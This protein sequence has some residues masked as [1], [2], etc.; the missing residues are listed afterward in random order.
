MKFIRSS[1]TAISPLYLPQIYLTGLRFPDCAELYACICRYKLGMMEPAWDLMLWCVLMNRHELA[2]FFWKRCSQPITAAL[3]CIHLYR[4]AMK[5]VRAEM[6]D[7]IQLSVAE[8]EKLAVEVQQEA[9]NEDIRASLQHLESP[10]L[11]WG[12]WTGYD[13]AVEGD[14]REFVTKCC[15]EANNERWYGDALEDTN[16][17]VW[18]ILLAVCLTIYVSFFPLFWISLA[19]QFG[20]HPEIDKNVTSCSILSPEG[21]PWEDVTRHETALVL[22]CVTGASLGLLL[23]A[24]CLLTVAILKIQLYSDFS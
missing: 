23:V 5:D 12:G 9:M 10:S 3:T 6:C 20:T 1:A 7:E 18:R 15:R 19:F 14:C 22:W 8:F 16:H 2:I 13:L 21:V 24:P 4:A 17:T 11:I